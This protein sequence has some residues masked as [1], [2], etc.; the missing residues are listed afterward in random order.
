MIQTDPCE[1][2]KLFSG[3]RAELAAPRDR[4]R[5][6]SDRAAHTTPDAIETT[7]VDVQ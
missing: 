6:R 5:S 1:L 4:A 3:Y 7:T 2:D